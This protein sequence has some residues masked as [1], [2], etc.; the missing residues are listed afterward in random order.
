MRREY[1]ATFRDELIDTETITKGEWVG[2]TEPGGP[3]YV[4]IEENFAK[5][6]LRVDI[7]DELIFNVQGVPI[8]TI[9]GSFREVDFARMQTNFM[10]VFPEGVLEEA[11]QF[12][13][14]ITRVEDE[15]TSA[16]F[17][18]S[19]AQTYPTISLIDLGLV[20]NTL[21]DILNKVSFVIRFM[22]LFSILTGLIVLAGSVIISRFQRIQE[23]ILLRTLGAS[24]R[25][26]LTINALEYFLLGF[27]ASMTGVVL[28][29]GSSWGLA[30]FSFEIV[31]IP[32]LVPMLVVVALITSLTVII[33]LLNSGGVL[34]RPPLEVL[35]REG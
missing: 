35:R 21:E 22:A 4:S 34:S 15:E 10:V 17:Q 24:R 5:E 12:H 19:V 29:L 9:V 30:T 7:G 13:V 31:F 11:P 14:L 33:G 28:S 8:P 16:A 6:D 27:L 2:K 3:V 25:Q 23:S 1:R 20:L 32:N 18:R 26:V